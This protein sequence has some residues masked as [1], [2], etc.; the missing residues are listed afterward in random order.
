MRVALTT[1]RDRCRL[2]AP[3]FR[4]AGLIP[5]VLPC[6][7]FRPDS[8]GIGKARTA[9]VDADW[10]VLTS[11][12]AVTV[13]WP[14]GMPPVPAAAVGEATA[15]A[16]SAAGGR[17]E[18]MGSA[19]A[20]DLL[21]VLAGRIDGA[22]VVFPHARDADPA[23]VAG[24]TA[25]GALVHAFPVYS[26]LPVPPGADEVEAAVF[27]SPSAVGGWLLS[28]SLAGLVLAAIGPTTASALET[29]GHPPHLVPERPGYDELASALSALHRERIGI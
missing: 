16:V 20:E 18:V 10:I 23:T 4:E 29:R 2:V 11:S 22:K 8:E 21:T 13:T 7:E 28:R 26:T 5:V 1:T 14:D 15:A 25:S 12:R 19:G 27:A 6:I 3:R 9:A 24:L 17:V